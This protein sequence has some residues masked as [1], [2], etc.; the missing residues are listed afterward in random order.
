MSEGD[1]LLIAL[2]LACSL[3]RATVSDTPVSCAPA[4]LMG[5][6]GL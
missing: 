6:D 5:F 2:K 4:F 3:R 1:I